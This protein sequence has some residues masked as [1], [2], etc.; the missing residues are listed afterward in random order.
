MWVQSFPRYLQDC[1]R[2]KPASKYP[3]VK[4][5]RRKVP[6]PPIYASLEVYRQLLAVNR[7]I[8]ASEAN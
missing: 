7:Q 2:N 6:P 8:L 1:M 3:M 4:I 5:S